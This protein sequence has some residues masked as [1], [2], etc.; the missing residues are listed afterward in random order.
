[1]FRV[2]HS[3][4]VPSQAKSNEA[5]QHAKDGPSCQRIRF[6]RGPEVGQDDGHGYLQSRE[7]EL[8]HEQEGLGGIRTVPL[9]TEMDEQKIEGSRSSE[10]DHCETPSRLGGRRVSKAERYNGKRTH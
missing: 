5:E 8:V 3:G 2:S 6:H 4:A 9:C 1:M 7:L 10:R